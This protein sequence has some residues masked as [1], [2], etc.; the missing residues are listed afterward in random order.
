M[1]SELYTHSDFIIVAKPPCML[2]HGHPRFPQ[3][4]ALIE[5][6]QE[7][8]ERD[9]FIVHR[10]D[11]SASGCI[12]VAKHSSVVADLK[13]HLRRGHKSYIALVRGV[14]TH[15]SPLRVEFPI[16]S[17]NGYKEASSEVV[18]LATQSQPRS[19]LLLVHPFTGRFHQVRRHV[20]D[21]GHP[22]LGDSEHGDSKLNRW[23]RMHMGLK[24]LAL[25]ALRLRLPSL[26]V[27]VHCPLFPDQ[28][29][30]FTRLE[31]WTHAQHKIKWQ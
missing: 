20:R 3:E 26:D 11:R 25:H 13:E 27:D 29:E 21:L 6:L 7:Q 22:I 24:R 9:L 23:W 31:L 4:R 14:Y 16:K 12:L 30:L 19:S 1:I 15:D 8:Y 5:I 10:L 17:K 2:T 28:V 18:C